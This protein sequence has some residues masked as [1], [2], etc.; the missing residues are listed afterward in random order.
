MN[1]RSGSN[2]NQLF[3][4]YNIIMPLMIVILLITVI[5]VAFNIPDYLLFLKPIL[6]VT[7]AAGEAGTA[8]TAAAVAKP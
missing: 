2:N 5:I 4:F 3:W 7:K 1:S 8:I 6:E